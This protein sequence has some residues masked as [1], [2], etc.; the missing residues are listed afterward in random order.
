MRLL[1][2][3]L[4]TRALAAILATPPLAHADPLDLAV[5]QEWSVKDSPLKVV[6]GHIDQW[7]GG[8]IVVSVSL[9]NPPAGWAHWF[10][11]IPFDKPALVASLDKLL[12]TGVAPD[13][14]FEARYQQWQSVHGGV[15]AVSVPQA[16]ADGMQMLEGSAR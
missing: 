11:H 15:F 1:R 6:I 9:S 13:T 8:E 10:S 14:A 2:R 16:V 12:A 5:G 4:L 3:Q 7:G